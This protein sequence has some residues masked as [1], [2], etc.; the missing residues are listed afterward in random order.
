MSSSRSS[1]SDAMKAVGSSVSKVGDSIVDGAKKVADV[2][3]KVVDGVVDS[4]KRVSSFERR[5]SQSKGEASFARLE[6]GGKSSSSV[7]YEAEQEPPPAPAEGDMMA[8][9]RASMSGIPSPEAVQ[10]KFTEVRQSLSVMPEKLEDGMTQKTFGTKLACALRTTSSHHHRTL[11]TSPLSHLDASTGRSQP[12]RL[13]PSSHSPVILGQAT[14]WCLCRSVRC[15]PRCSRCRTR[16][17]SFSSCG[18]LTRTASCTSSSASRP[19]PSPPPLPPPPPPPPPRCTARCRSGRS[20]RTSWSS[21]P[22]ASR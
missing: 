17:H 2:P 6:E 1:F 7:G 19:A 10:A 18:S 11:H 13:L 16:W 5:S 4:A 22:S 21:M 8:Q 3:G 12:S 20:T 9:M 15:W 14:G